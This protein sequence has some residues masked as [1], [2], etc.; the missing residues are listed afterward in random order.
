[1]KLEA[2]TEFVTLARGASKRIALRT[3]I[4]KTSSLDEPLDSGTAWV[5]VT[6]RVDIANFAPARSKV[7]YELGQFTVD[8]I[9]FKVKGIKW[10]LANAFD[11]AIG[12]KLECKVEFTIEGAADIVYYFSGWIDAA[13]AQEEEITD[14]ISFNAYSADELGN[15]IPAESVS[16]Q[17]IFENV[18]GA[19]HDGLILPTLVGIYVIDA[20]LA[21]YEVL[22]GTH[23]IGFDPDQGL[24]FDGGKWV[25]AT[26]G[27][28]VTLGNAQDPAD[29]TQRIK[30]YINSPI[31]PATTTYDD[32][33]QVTAGATLPNRWYKDISIRFLL[34]KLYEKIGMISSSFDTL[35]FNTYDSAKRFSYVDT[36]PGNTG[37]VSSEKRAIETDG[38]NLWIAVGK[39]LWR[40]DALTGVYEKK[41]THTFFIDRL[42][43][44]GRNN[45]IWMYGAGAL[46]RY[47]IG[48]GTLSADINLEEGTPS[49]LTHL[50]MELV[51]WNYAGSSYEYA[52]VYTNDDGATSRGKLMRVD[53]ASLS[54]TTITTGTTLAYTTGNGIRSKFMHQMAAGKIR[55]RV[56]NNTGLEA[57][58][59]Y[60]VSGAGAWTDNGEKIPGIDNY[61]RA[62]AYSASEDRIYYWFDDGAGS[63]TL[64]SH[65][66]SSATPTLVV[67]LSPDGLVDCIYYSPGD[68]LTYFTSDTVDGKRLF[69]IASNVATLLYGDATTQSVY[70]FY[71]QMVWA[72]DR[73][74]VLNSAVT[75]LV[76]LNQWCNKV[77]ASL[78]LA[79]F[80]DTSVYEAI[81]KTLNSFL[82]M[83]TVS[84]SKRAIVFRRADDAG[85]PTTTGKV[86]SLGRNEISELSSVLLQYPKADLIQV[87]AASKIVTYDG[88]KFDQA[89]LSDK[90]VI[91][92]SN[93][94]IPDAIA[95][96]LAFYAYQ[97]FK[98][99]RS[100]YTV[101][102]GSI[103]LF[104][105]EPFDQ[106]DLTLIGTKITGT[107]SGPIYSIAC[108]PEGSVTVEGLLKLVPLPA[109]GWDPLDGTIRR[110]LFWGKAR[111]ETAYNDNDPVPSFT[112]FSGNGN[113]AVQATLAKQPTFKK[114]ILNGL[115]VLRFD[116]GDF[117]ITPAFSGSSG[118]SIY[119]VFN[120]TSG[121]QNGLFGSQQ[122]IAMLIEA[123][124]T[125]PYPQV[126]Y[127][128]G[129]NGVI[130]LSDNYYAGTTIVNGTWYVMSYRRPN[131][132]GTGEMILNDASI[133]TY[134]SGTFNAFPHLTIG[135]YDEAGTLGFVGDLEEVFLYDGPMTADED[136]I[137]RSYLKGVSS[138]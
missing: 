17:P 34:A 94:F 19:G 35:E 9:S 5:E 72:E 86:L 1:M 48:S 102:A 13:G 84:F 136:A 36:P 2:S 42:F 59:E 127:V 108:S 105:Y 95:K 92:I 96:D 111:G 57:Y 133:G 23:A 20:A 70:C 28:T 100:L 32:I 33:V 117:L 89:V 55:F 74:W 12:E 101:K 119:A 10:W 6:N 103:P 109:D 135:A 60:Q 51:D 122:V 66:S 7:E 97:F 99:D 11:L 18:D 131:P 21:G 58:R 118:Y 25:A 14:A 40:R 24:N 116:G 4:R 125:P 69:S 27:A 88:S 46:R 30:V 79:R 15:R 121:T 44:N 82:L 132:G 137:I 134:G 123:S 22:L 75:Y 39:D 107:G 52:F 113:H 128:E 78:T 37:I 91:Q 104:Q 83:G 138:L 65:T 71:H 80:K 49:Q 68:N 3:F 98:V 31:I 85:V 53:G 38:Q 61:T 126:F 43:Y 54:I 90:R 16:C 120:R 56:Y 26:G 50:S 67:D 130:Y 115:P 81:K 29:D 106:L 77:V 112:D 87:N 45:H 129:G 73:L 64:S 41:A 62:I 114:N 76:T 124:A 93:D 110:P 47:N 8:S 63:V